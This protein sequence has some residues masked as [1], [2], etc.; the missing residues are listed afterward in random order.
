MSLTGVLGSMLV[1]RHFDKAFEEVEDYLED[2]N[3]KEL[4]R[5]RDD[6][7]NF[8]DKYDRS[9]EFVDDYFEN[10]YGWTFAA[11]VAMNPV[12]SWKQLAYCEALSNIEYDQDMPD[13][14]F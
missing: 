14:T 7:S 13:S 1:R 12:K 11:A 4:S 3:R 8:V 10:P 2:G 5:I 6:A 9:L